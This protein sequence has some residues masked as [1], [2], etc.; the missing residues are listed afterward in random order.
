MEEEV[1]ISL[2]IEVYPDIDKEVWGFCL[3]V[4]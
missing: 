2:D 4:F 1:V 3:F